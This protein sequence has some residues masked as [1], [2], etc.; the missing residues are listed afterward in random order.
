[1]TERRFGLILAIGIVTGLTLMPVAAGAAQQR[2]EPAV[3]NIGWWWEESQTEE[4]DVQGNKVVV[5]TPNPFCPGPG[6]GLGVVTSA[7]AE[8]SFAVEIIGG[9]YVTP[10]K[11][12]GLGFDL[13]YLTP[14]SEV[15]SFTVKLLES[16][17]G[18]TDGPDEGTE[19]TPGV[20]GAEGDFVQQTNPT[21]PVDDRQVQ[22]CLLTQIFGDAEGGPYK[23]VPS[24]ECSDSDP[25]ASRK[26]I[27]T[28]DPDTDTDEVDYVWEFDLTDY[29]QRWADEF[30]V[31]T[32]IMLVGKEPQSTDQ[33]DSWRVVFAGPKI[34]K[35][36]VTELVYEPGEIVIAP[37][38]VPPTSPTDPFTGSTGT[39]TTDFGT[40]TTDFGTGVA[41]G[42]DTGVTPP[43]PGASP[44][45]APDDG[46]ASDTLPT[47]SEGLPP[48]VWLALIAGV[49]GFTLVRQVVIE[50]ATGIRP[51]GV[52]AKIHALNADRRGVAA[53]EVSDASPLAGLAALGGK[54]KSL[55]S[56]LPFGRK[57]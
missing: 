15:I 55:F 2:A 29:A 26:E 5:G 8:G 37:P 21:G 43:A 16:E 31:A 50:S 42:D 39:G 47:G 52:L 17:A 18:C 57:G 7:C 48:Y 13:S 6:N 54:A 24:Y 11:L 23:E 22:A 44:S 51:D 53:T 30:S 49:I 3:L 1:M 38:V 36:I 9:D 12:S 28:V 32:N 34:R 20:P 56:K 14:G 27:K 33:T 46:L 25:V 40:G 35:G 41:P 10:N 19:C 4:R 45:A